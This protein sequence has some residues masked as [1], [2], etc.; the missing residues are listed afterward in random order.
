[1]SFPNDVDGDVLRRLEYN[2]FNFE[3]EAVVDFN[4]DFNHWPLNS[5]EKEA[6]VKLYPN[7][8]FYDPDD[9]DIDNGDLNGYVQFTIFTK[10]EHGFIVKIQRDVTNQMKQ[11]GGWCDSWGVAHW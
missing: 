2:G 9:E 1:M 11:F 6:I 3:K 5:N 4:I 8:E 10:I 7:C